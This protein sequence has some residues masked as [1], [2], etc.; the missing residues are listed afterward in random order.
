MF[1]VA[2]N[3]PMIRRMK[4]DDANSRVPPLA[5]FANGRHDEIRIDPPLAYLAIG[6]NYA[7]IRMMEAE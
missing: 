2:G 3:Y 1:A 5:D 7:I 6:G 4:S